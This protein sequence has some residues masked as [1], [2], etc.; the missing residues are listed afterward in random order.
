MLCDFK[1][2]NKCTILKNKH[3]CAIIYKSLNNRRNVSICR[4]I[5]TNIVPIVKQ[6]KSRVPSDAPS[7]NKYNSIH[8]KSSDSIETI[9][10][11]VNSSSALV[12]CIICQYSDMFSG[13]LIKKIIFFICFGLVL[14]SCWSWSQVSVGYLGLS[15]LRVELLLFRRH[16]AQ[17][18]PGSLIKPPIQTYDC[19]PY[20]IG[21]VVRCIQFGSSQSPLDF[22]PA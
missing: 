6:N 17:I 9:T 1:N 7:N 13:T 18:L 20:R 16:L 8:T 4:T 21:L 19:L 2:R 22:L 3:W 5:S 11:T 14:V 12:T 15:L 10:H